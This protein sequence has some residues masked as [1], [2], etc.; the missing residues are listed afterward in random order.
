LFYERE[1]TRPEFPQFFG[2]RNYLFIENH[3]LIVFDLSSNKVIKVFKEVRE[4]IEINTNFLYSEGILIFK[5]GN[6][7]LCRG[8]HSK[9][10]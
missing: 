8:K 1:K 10:Y 5:T 9:N 7:F 3:K 4:V 6:S 2:F